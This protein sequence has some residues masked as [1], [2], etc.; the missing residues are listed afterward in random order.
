M[1]RLLQPNTRRVQLL[2]GQGIAEWWKFPN[3]CHQRPAAQHVYNILANGREH[4]P[5]F[6]RLIVIHVSAE[7]EKK[8][9]TFGQWLKLYGGIVTSPW[10]SRALVLE[11]D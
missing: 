11:F 9:T 1:S 5:G 7:F 10:Y 8:I 2:R 3:K 4:F 6:R